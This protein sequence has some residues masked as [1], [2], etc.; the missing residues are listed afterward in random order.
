MKLRLL[1]CHIFVTAKLTF[2]LAVY[3]G[4][5][6][7]PC[8]AV[9]IACFLDYHAD[10]RKMEFQCGFNSAYGV[11]KDDEHFSC[12]NIYWPRVPLSFWRL[13]FLY[14][15]DINFCQM[16]SYRLSPKILINKFGGVAKGF[17]SRFSAC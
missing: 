7:P 6:L 1:I 8:S 9:F 4:F 16:N 2:P 14:I 10:R 3:K 12:V 13:T 17:H 5:P 15:L 11:S